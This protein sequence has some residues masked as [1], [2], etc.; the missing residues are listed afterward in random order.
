MQTFM[1]I[2]VIR[3]SYDFQFHCFKTLYDVFIQQEGCYINE[4]AIHGSQN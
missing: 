2:L 4:S 1:P 3:I